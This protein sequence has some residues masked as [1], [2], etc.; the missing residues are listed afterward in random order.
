MTKIDGYSYRL[1]TSPVHTA[2]SPVK[3]VSDTRDPA[4]RT[5]Q[6]ELFTAAL[7]NAEARHQLETRA[8]LLRHSV[9]NEG[10]SRDGNI[11]VVNAYLSLQIHQEREEISN[12]IG[13]NEYA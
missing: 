10:M 9:L 4:H 13:V 7:P 3:S 5:I 1:L 8:E 6:Q 2:L 12:L 11:S